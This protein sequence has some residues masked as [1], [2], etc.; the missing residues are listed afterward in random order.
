[1][2]IDQKF[3]RIL[4]RAAELRDGLAS[5]IGGEAFV[6]ASREL[7]ELVPIE[8]RINA[9]NEA[10]KAHDDAEAM[11]ADPEMKALA[12]AEIFELKQ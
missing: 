12:E 10:R 9:L 8:E 3:D 11:L 5:G 4:A 1:M 6:A 2:N 7:S